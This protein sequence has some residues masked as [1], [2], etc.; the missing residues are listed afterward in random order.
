MRLCL[1][2]SRAALLCFPLSSDIKAAFTLKFT[3]EKNLHVLYRQA[4]FFLLIF[5]CSMFALSLVLWY[6]II[7]YTS[8]FCCLDPP[9][10]RFSSDI[11]KYPCVLDLFSHSLLMVEFT[12]I[13]RGGIPEKHFSLV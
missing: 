3:F 5:S 6:P 8:F 12:E 4:C 10:L 11:V 9:F 7:T 2:G 13:L 1:R